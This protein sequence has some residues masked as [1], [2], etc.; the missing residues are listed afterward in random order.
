MKI[1]FSTSVIQR[2]KTGIAQYIFALLRAFSTEATTERFT[3]F[4]LE[5]DR[6]FFKGLDDRFEIVPVSEK[7]R[8]A[9]KNIRWHQTVLPGIA[10]QLELDVLHVP[11]YRRLMWRKPCPLVATIHDLAPFR[12]SGKYDI[13]R[14]FYGR[15]VVKHLARRQDEIITVSHNT[16]L[17]IEQFFKIS[18]SDLRVIHNGIEHDRFFPRPAE[19]A[20]AFVSQK[21]RL[22]KP[23]FLYVARLEHP[24]KNHR[25][26]IEAFERFKEQT[27][28]DWIL[29]F[30][31]SD[32]HGA[33]L[34]HARIAESA[35][36]SDIRT[37]GFISNDD[38]PQLYS[39]A[40]AFVYPSLYEGFGLPPL[41]AMACG[42]PVISSERG[43]LGEV[44]GDAAWIVE[45]EDVEDICDALIKLQ[46]EPKSRAALVQKGL[47]HSRE[48]SWE[49]A[50]R[51]TLAVYRRA[52][53]NATNSAADPLRTLSSVRAQRD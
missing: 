51:E 34:I 7:F 15:V 39:A 44:V 47:A 9:V 8:P 13:A 10:R 20:R 37:L 11:S 36:G 35:Y 23:F 43:S 40:E 4:V 21:Y 2:G 53:Q 29:A 45:P 49:R 26:L 22:N 14:M 42:C 16:A 25:R 46:S 17:D 48:F 38:L 24:G 28:S 31:G 32:W 52:Y 33:E 19:E 18:K 27:Q 1:G 3:L 50:A 30:G 41:E 6:E 5:E 12:V